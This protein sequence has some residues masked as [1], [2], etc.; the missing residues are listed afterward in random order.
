MNK[1][2]ELLEQFAVFNRLL[3][4]R[5]T[6][7]FRHFGP[8]GSVFRGQGR[9]LAILKIKKEMSQKELGYLLD[10]RNQSLGEILGKL[11]TAGYISR[12]PSED[13][14][15]TALIRLT[16]LGENEADTEKQAQS[17]GAFDRVFAC[18]EDS[19]QQALAD[20]LSR[21]IAAIKEQLSESGETDA[22]AEAH[23]RRRDSC[24]R[25]HGHRGEEHGHRFYREARTGRD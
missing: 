15:R 8:S 13:D 3:H 5:H 23:N 16:P 10:M 12:S 25:R 2:N 9:V 18:L 4:R 1:S 20:Y 24:G 17:E 6:A 19:E 11:E 21:L 22:D 7:Q 14:K